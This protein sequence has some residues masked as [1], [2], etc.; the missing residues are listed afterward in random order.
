MVSRLLNEL[1][2][3]AVI[4]AGVLGLSETDAEVWREAAVA[5]SGLIAWFTVRANI[6]GPVTL[7][8]QSG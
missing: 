7:S 4:V 3:I 6:N 1:P 5:V 2:T 8:K